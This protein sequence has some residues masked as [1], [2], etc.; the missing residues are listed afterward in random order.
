M[1][2]VRDTLLVT[3]GMCMV[4]AK[5]AA[6]EEK[7]FSALCFTLEGFVSC[8]IFTQSHLPGHILCLRKM[9]CEKQWIFFIVVKETAICI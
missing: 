2:F 8:S 3:K 1:A 4:I 9:L 6:D 5:K 7:V